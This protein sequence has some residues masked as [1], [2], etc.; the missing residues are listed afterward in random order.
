MQ[1]ILRRMIFVAGIFLA[2]PW[3]RAEERVSVRFSD[4][5]RP[6]TV[7]VE[8]IDGNIT[9]KAYAGSEVLVEAQTQ[10]KGGAAEAV[11]KKATGMKRL[12][13][14][15]IGLSVEEVDNVVSVSVKTDD[16]EVNL[17]VQVPV[18]TSLKL[19]SVDGEIQVEGVSG[20][21]EIHAVDGDVRLNKVSG[22]VV[23]NSVDGD[24]VVTLEK[25]DLAKPMSF[26]SVDGDIDVSFPPDLK[27]LVKIKAD[28]GEVYTD[29]EV[30]IDSSAGKPIIEDGRSRG[31]RYRV[32]TDKTIVGTINGGG[33]E[34]QFK[35][36]D[37][38]V[39]IRRTGK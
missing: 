12:D 10:K 11:P 38:D 35:T 9:V 16:N 7:K 18:A 5:A 33:P 17:V 36:A 21:L 39:F 30:R 23:A 13:N 4:P 24:I 19:S 22:T 29:F 6:K 27:A 14:S 15:R 25:V 1:Q 28:D 26:S 20:E 34:I 3:S 31:G 37:G 8:V 32:L 2:V